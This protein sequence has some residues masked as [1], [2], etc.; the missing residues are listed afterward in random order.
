MAEYRSTN[1]T[2]VVGRH[3]AKNQPSRFLEFLR[4]LMNVGLN[5]DGY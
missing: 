5:T 1:A 4:R 3:R 2:V